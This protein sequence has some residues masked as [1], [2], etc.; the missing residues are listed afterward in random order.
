MRH[1]YLLAKGLTRPSPRIRSRANSDF[2]AWGGPNW[3]EVT[4]RR[5]RA[6]L[7]ALGAVEILPLLSGVGFGRYLEPDIPYAGTAAIGLVLS[8]LLCWLLRHQT[9]PTVIHAVSHTPAQ[10]SSPHGSSPGSRNGSMATKIE[11]DISEPRI[12]ILG[13]V[14]TL[15]LFLSL[16][17]CL[18]GPLAVSQQISSTWLFVWPPT[19]W[20][21]RSLASYVFPVVALVCLYLGRPTVRS[22]RV[23]FR[24]AGLNL[25]LALVLVFTVWRIESWSVTMTNSLSAGQFGSSSASALQSGIVGQGI[26]NVPL[27]G[28]DGR[29]VD[30]QALISEAKVTVLV[31]WASYDTPWS[32]NVK[33]ATAIHRDTAE[34]GVA[35]VAINED[36]PLGGVKSFVAAR[37]VDFPILSD[38]NGKLFREPGLLGSVEQIVVAD[39]TGR[40]IAHFKAPG[41]E[42]EMKRIIE[43][44][45][46]IVP[47]TAPSPAGSTLKND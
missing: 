41:S 14:F 12:T 11:N 2:V 44:I 26:P 15:V 1:W 25:A 19:F 39:D 42:T 3:S 34:K 33:L 10:T 24:I 30:L 22:S 9:P 17:V 47:T 16:L 46:E 23:S 31:F 5:V 32:K 35:V 43:T 4:P 40:V 8:V 13:L 38:S 21:V 28:L 20:I 18:A 29:I 36:E 27:P 45:Y 6:R 37:G 7:F